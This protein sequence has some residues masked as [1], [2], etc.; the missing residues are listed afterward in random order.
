MERG[1]NI[2]GDYELFDIVGQ[3][4][5]ATVWEARNIITNCPCACK[6][7]QLDQ[8]NSEVLNSIT[9]EIEILK[10]L[11]HPLIPDLYEV[12]ETPESIYIFMEYLENGTLLEYINRNKIVPESKARLIF[13][14]LITVLDYL[15]NEKKVVHRDI[16]AENILLDAN[17]NIRLIDFGLS[18]VMNQYTSALHTACG[19]SAYAAPEMLL[20]KPY[21]QAADIWSAGVVLFAM[22]CSSLP[23]EDANMTRLIDKVLNSEPNFASSVGYNLRDLISK[24]LTKDPNA[25]ISLEGI[26]AHPWVT[27][28]MMGGTVIYNYHGLDK[29]RIVQPSGTVTLDPEIVERLLD[30]QVDTNGLKSDLLQRHCTRATA[31]YR[32]FHREQTLEGLACLIDDLI[33]RI[34][35][36]LS[37]SSISVGHQIAL[38]DI[39]PKKNAT[40]PRIKGSGPKAPL[41]KNPSFGK[42]PLSGVSKVP[43][44]NGILNLIIPNVKTR[45]STIANHVVTRSVISRTVIKK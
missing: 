19:S 26:K 44:R 28:D 35:K 11:D 10:I 4:T 22:A 1:G 2:I 20:G 31:A 18:N 23:F 36:P 8:I 21:T 30:F 32:A 34:E 43:S 16:K 41:A 3:G 40:E 9:R 14:Q 33:V 15:H 17:D 6:Q 24:M 45:Q 5:F 25:R 13:I 39:T 27:S 29:Y 7:V 38:R 12:I 42:G 37:M